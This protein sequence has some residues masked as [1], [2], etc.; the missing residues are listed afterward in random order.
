MQVSRVAGCSEYLRGRYCLSP[1]H[2]SHLTK[3]LGLCVSGGIEL[4]ETGGILRLWRA[5]FPSRVYIL[6]Y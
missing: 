5:S 2:R 3:S 6:D 4:I 1:A